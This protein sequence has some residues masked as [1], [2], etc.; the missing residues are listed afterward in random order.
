MLAAPV[1]PEKVNE[2]WVRADWEI[3]NKTTSKGD[4]WIR[5]RA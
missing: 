4:V 1:D 3:V 2:N 5:K